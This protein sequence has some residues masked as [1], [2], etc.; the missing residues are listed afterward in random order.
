MNSFNLPKI[1]QFTGE[2]ITR[3]RQLAYQLEK[4]EEDRQHVLFQAT[5]L[6]SLLYC[7]ITADK[8]VI[9]NWPRLQEE[10][11]K[12][13]RTKANRYLVYIVPDSIVQQSH[14]YEELT[15]AERDDKFFR[16]VFIGLPDGA[17]KKEIEQ[18]LAD[19]IPLWF[20]ERTQ[21]IRQY[22]PVVS[23]LVPDAALLK[24]LLQGTPSSVVRAI[25]DQPRFA[26]LLEGGSQ[27]PETS[28][29]LEE[30]RQVRT[31]GRRGTR[32]TS[33]QLKDF[34]RFHQRTIDLDGDVVLIYGKNGTG[35]TTLCD[36]LELSI[37][38]DL[39]RLHGDPDLIQAA[40]HNTPFMRAGS[41]A[42]SARV[43]VS[44]S[45]G[46]KS[47]LLETVVTAKAMEKTLDGKI[48]SPEEVVRFLTRNENV[49]KKGF[50]DILLHTHFLGQH[51]IRDFIYGNRL[52]DAEKITTTRYNLLS[53]MFG[54][55]EV[56]QLKK[57]LTGVLTQIK[58]SK[59]SDAENQIEAALRQVRGLHQKY[60]PKCRVEL[61]KKGFQ[62]APD[63]AIERY[64]RAIGQ[65]E[66][67]FGKNFV[68]QLVVAQPPMENYMTSCE[69]AHKLLAEHLKLLEKQSADLKQL[70]RLLARLH[71][72]FPE[73]GDLDAG[74]VKTSIAR[75]RKHIDTS[76]ESVAVAKHEVQAISPLIETLTTNVAQLKKFLDQHGHY[77]QLCETERKQV[78]TLA[79]LQNG[80]AELLG[81][82]GQLLEQ[83][84]L[85]TEKENTNARL[86]AEAEERGQ[87]IEQFR[88]L[89]PEAKSAAR[90]LQEQSGKIAAITEKIIQAEQRLTQLNQ[91]PLPAGQT[92]SPISFD[93]VSLRTETHFL[94]PC[95]GAGYDTQAEIE[96]AIQRQLQHGK[97][98]QELRAFLDGLEQ[99]NTETTKSHLIE[100]LALYGREKMELEQASRVK[101]KI[102]TNFKNLAANLGLSPDWSEDDIG[103]LIQK[104]DQ[105]TQKLK[106]EQ[107]VQKT[108][109][110][111]ET[112][113]KIDADLANLNE[114]VHKKYLTQ[115]QTEI[116]QIRKTVAGILNLDQLQDHTQVQAQFDSL[117]SQLQEREQR[118]S[119]LQIEIKVKE[120][121][122]E[123]L[124]EIDVCLAEIESLLLSHHNL[125]DYAPQLSSAF[126]D[127]N[128]E[129]QKVCHD[130]LAETAELQKLFGFL[131]AE[132]RGDTIRKTLH[133]FEAVK[134]RWELCYQSIEKINTDL[135]KL[136]YTGL[137]QSLA[138]Y[139]PLINQIYQKF[140]RHDIFA[141]L[142]LQPSSS[143][144][145]RRRDLYLRLKSYSGKEEYTPASYLSEAQLNILALSI[146]LTRV[147]YQNISELDT[148]LIDDPI[149]QMDDM[150]SAAFVD[151]ILGLSQIGKQII[152]TTCNQDFYRLV[153]HKMQNISAAG[154]ISFKSVNLDSAIMA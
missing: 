143:Q 119:A 40:G 141:S 113:A 74:M 96:Q 108:T 154:R 117:T 71:T 137:Q 44:G 32:I 135:S 130:F 136:S 33:L 64:N 107:A 9:G 75:A 7:Q 142:I 110:L 22:V 23:E 127:E 34:R 124:R 6:F 76:L 93:P 15:R 101:A 144:K 46:D 89:L 10:L 131:T 16:K 147:M 3:N 97:Y 78:E 81:R 123:R 99:R 36:A 95:C 48:I 79:G 153:A 38:P 132:E 140:I 57:R 66:K 56:E 151:V 120:I 45:S 77:L 86:L 17:G 84:R 55:G 13:D 29:A 139:G 145:A 24:I 41:S 51:S 88:N 4:L 83:L 128:L 70:V 26:Y 105:E 19:R 121:P 69:T 103:S 102:C 1:S 12:N 112:V 94:C 82:R 104:Q 11:F 116:A 54:F 67:T 115:T 21:I 20:E 152:I 85:A 5:N 109:S 35:K 14:L 47:F 68:N 138:Q 50:L 59:I 122:P 18:S 73:V 58:K 52:D 80:K 98:A 149:Q 53:E 27:S 60:G 49:Q 31:D 37:Y 118:K 2:F 134:K 72:I 65:L 106:D 61:E 62:I 43:A 146:F 126:G 125:Q 28:K 8:E 91:R 111:R 150:N 92:S 63:F 39:R 90:A 87:K 25:E 114:G 129:K 100:T 30:S 133:E 148:V 42:K